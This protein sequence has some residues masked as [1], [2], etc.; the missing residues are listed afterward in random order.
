M[1]IIAK[2]C[3]NYTYEFYNVWERYALLRAESTYFSSSFRTTENL[4]K[5]CSLACG[6]SFIQPKFIGYP[7]IRFGDNYSWW[8]M[9]FRCTQ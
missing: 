8:N 2:S 3:T 7:R 6:L 1:K 4:Y 5:P 9:S